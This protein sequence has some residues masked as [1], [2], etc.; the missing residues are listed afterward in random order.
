M[1]R[2]RYKLFT[3]YGKVADAM[4][5][6]GARVWKRP[7][8]LTRPG[9]TFEAQGEGPFGALLTGVHQ[10]RPEIVH[11]ARHLAIPCR[12]AEPAG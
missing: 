2:P 12:D 11:D 9:M 1:A 10:D 7:L 3:H 4:A 8:L 5:F 6:T